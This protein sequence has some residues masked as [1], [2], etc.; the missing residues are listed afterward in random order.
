MS[1]Q[2]NPDQIQ[3]DGVRVELENPET[4]TPDNYTVITTYGFDEENV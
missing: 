3:V 2:I 4:D 1:F